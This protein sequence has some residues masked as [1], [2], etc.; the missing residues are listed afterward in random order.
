VA[1]SKEGTT[2]VRL[3]E[4]ERQIIICFRQCSP[5]YKHYIQALCSNAASRSRRKLPLNVVQ[6]QQIKAKRG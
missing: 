1:Q 5:T 6:L 3:D 2:L 4:D